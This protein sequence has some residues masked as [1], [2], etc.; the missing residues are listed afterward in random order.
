MTS[1]LRLVRAAAILAMVIVVAAC[2][3][4]SSDGDLAPSGP[5]GTV[6]TGPLQHDDD[7]GE[8]PAISGACVEGEPDCT[9]T[10]V[11]GDDE[12]LPPPGD[13]PVPPPAGGAVVSGGMLADGGLT[14]SDA[15]ATDATGTIAVKGFLLVDDSGARLCEL[16]AESFPP[17]CGGASI[18]VAGY[19]EVIR[20]PLTTAQ[21][22]TWTDGTVALLGEIIDGT[23]V[24]DPTVAG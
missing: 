17:Q 16:L 14:V 1:A 4:G 23:L 24:V 18:P 7:P 5:A 12:P 11:V 19:E 3:D 9:D 6:D 13:E 15:L 21:G 2:G 8:H 10:I 22:I 20:E